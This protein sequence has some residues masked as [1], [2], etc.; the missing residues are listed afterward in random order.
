V[1]KVLYVIGTLD[2][3]GTERQLVELATRLDRARFEPVVCCL[4]SGGALE[5]PL[6]EA[7]IR[8]H[9]AGFRGFLRLRSLR[10]LA[11]LPRLLAELGRFLRV[12]LTERPDV[13]HGLLF[14]A[15]VLGAYAA[16]LARVKVVVS[17]RRSLSHFKAGRH[18][19][20]LLEGIANRMTD[21]VVANS[22]AVREDAL[23]TE[24][25]P[26]DK[27]VVVYNGL[28]PD[29]YLD[30]GESRLRMELHIPA[31][32]P[33]VLVVANFI[34]YKGHE[35]F[36]EAWVSVT[37]AYPGAVAVLIGDG[38]RRA[39]IEAQAA[40]LGVAASIR[41]VGT[42]LD[43]PAFLAMSDLVVHPSREEGF[44]NAVLEAMAAGRA[45]V[46]TAVGGNV[47]AVV[48]GQ[49]GLLVPYGD[50]H[51]L[52]SAI[53]RLFADADTR[54][55]FGAEGRARALARFGIGRMVK[56]YEALYERLMEDKA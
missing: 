19:F 6:K 46:A 40:Q 11:N 50:S 33:V 16:R 32:A 21:L 47:E 24:R 20:L 22:E 56:E 23:R 41:F 15:Y 4:S 9:V 38:P 54:S 36:V 12:F 43:V 44:S 34:H 3:G 14:W 25:L 17:S 26:P 31:T 10:F 29:R 27:V 53:T 18:H 37:E 49:T 45:V 7:G 35:H 52:A 51:V 8:V 1:I 39:A 48:D 30:R 5:Q 13:V 28:E 42:R 55:R 2:V